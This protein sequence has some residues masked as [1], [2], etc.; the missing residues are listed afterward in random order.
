MET[1]RSF[2]SHLMVL[3]LQLLVGCRSKLKPDQTF[4]FNRN[5]KNILV[6]WH[7][8]TGHTARSG[9]LMA[10]T[11]ENQ[12]YTVTASKISDFDSRLTEN[13]DL[14]VMGAPVFYYDIPGHVKQWIRSMSNLNGIPVAAFVTYGGPEGDQDNA[15]NTILE[16]LEKRGGIPVAK[17]TFMNMGAYPLSWSDSHVSESVWNNR[18]LPDKSAYG[19]IRKYAL[20]TIDCVHSGV[21]ISAEKKMTM[22]RFV[23]IFSPIW[24]TKRSI[25]KHFIDKQKCI[26]CLACQDNCPENAINV[27]MYTVDRNACSLCFGCLN[28]C[29]EKAMTMVYNDKKLIGFFDMLKINKIKIIVPKEFSS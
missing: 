9:R 10:L 24:W 15:V 21:R 18:H 20:H 23:T 13:F 25:E 6:L 22:R 29:P 16:L 12:G 8:Q 7:S 5:L 3:L 26:Q 4:V 17:A 11:L 27:S 1:R 19:K 28:V 2:L 14:I